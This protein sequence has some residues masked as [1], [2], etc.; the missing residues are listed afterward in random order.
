MG[1]FFEDIQ[2]L[3]RR[4][5][6]GHVQWGGACSKGEQF[7]IFLSQTVKLPSSADSAATTKLLFLACMIVS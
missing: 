2:Y 1:A 7:L 5:G 3:L 6:W 4:D